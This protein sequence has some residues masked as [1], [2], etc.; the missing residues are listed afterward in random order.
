MPLLHINTYTRI[1]PHIYTV[2]SIEKHK[3]GDIV[4]LKIVRRKDT[5]TDSGTVSP[6]D[7]AGPDNKDSSIFAYKSADDFITITVKLK[8]T[9]T[10]NL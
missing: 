9:S 4:D 3:I 2:K 6:A 8:L 7:V 10:D 5:D 1:Y